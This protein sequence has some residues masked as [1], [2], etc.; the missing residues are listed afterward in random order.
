[1]PNYCFKGYC[2]LRKVGNR[3]RD[4]TGC[5]TEVHIDPMTGADT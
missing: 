3:F 4:T 5:P 1:M 2:L